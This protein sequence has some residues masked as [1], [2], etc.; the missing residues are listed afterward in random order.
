MLRLPAVA[1][2]GA[3]AYAQARPFFAQLAG[4]E[5]AAATVTDDIPLAVYVLS[6]HRDVPRC[7]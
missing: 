2:T 5:F 4:F 1:R 6:R 7:H 3:G